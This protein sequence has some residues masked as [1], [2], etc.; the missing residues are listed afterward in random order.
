MSLANAVTRNLRQLAQRTGLAKSA[1][2]R[3]FDIE[4]KQRIT[5]SP[6]LTRFVFTGADVHLMNTLAPDQRVKLLFPGPDG[7]PPQLPHHDDWHQALRSL[8]PQRKPPMRTYTIRSLRSAQAEVD[9]EFVLHGENGPASRW[10]THARPGDRLQMVAPDGESAGDPGG[11]EWQPPAGIRHV[12]LIGDETA[13]PAIAGIL[14]ALADWPQPPAVQA[15]IEVPHAADRQ[16]LRQPGTAEVN[17]LVRDELA[18]EHGA[19]MRH[20]VL[21]LALLPASAARAKGRQTIE[22]VDIET[23]ILWDR[24]KPAD[25]EFYAWVAGESAAVMSIRRY[26]V[27]ELGLDR[28]ALT[29]MGYWRLGRALE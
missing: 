9:V 3:L 18:L 14:E 12:L 6:S 21:R 25:S 1:R 20:A 10:A 16:T 29:F 24:A 26:L 2:Y 19:G 15:F 5:V 17:W 8:E 13:L 11:Y 4:L 7:T 28:R 22:E 23:Q 27:G